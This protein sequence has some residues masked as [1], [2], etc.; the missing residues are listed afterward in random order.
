MI[1]LGRSENTE[2][3]GIV[4]RSRIVEIENADFFPS[5]EQFKVAVSLSGSQGELKAAK[6]LANH[7]RVYF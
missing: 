7:S 6:S 5:K 4:E 3:V 1:N 2:G